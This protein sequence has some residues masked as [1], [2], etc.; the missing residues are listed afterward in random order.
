MLTEAQ[1][2]LRRTGITA[3]DIGAIAGLNKFKSPMDVWLD[4]KGQ[5]E[6][7]QPND[8]IESG[9][10]LEEPLAQW[11]ADRQ[12]V[13]LVT[14]DTV[15]HPEH[16]WMLATPDRLHADKSRVVEIKNVGMRSAKRWDNGVPEM[17]T[18]QV[19]WQQGVTGIHD[20]VV[21]ALIGGTAYRMEP[22]PWDEEVANM[23]MEVGQEFWTAHV[24]K[25]IPPAIDASDA[26]AKHL[27][28]KFPKAVGEM[29]ATTPEAEVVASTYLTCK[30]Q[31]ARLKEDQAAAQHMLQSLI[32]GNRGIQ[33]DGWQ[34]TWTDKKGSV[35]W[36]A[37][38]KMFHEMH[39]KDT[40]LGEW[41]E[42]HRRKSTRIF[43]CKRKETP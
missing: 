8:A 24:L 26:W 5:A 1:L 39:C 34:A 4:K 42:K 12:G 9:N 3:T 21:V 25:D 2:K 35:D 33:G 10:R 17:T 40:T 14:C 6:E 37:V 19:I 7:V 22:V 28:E 43:A 36:K 27:R 15:R 31:I 29:V 41:A 20:G 30:E 23:L 18:A 13:E 11:Y 16:R 32:E 38:A